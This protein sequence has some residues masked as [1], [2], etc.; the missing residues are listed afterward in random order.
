M[1][2]FIKKYAL[3]TSAGGTMGTAS[4]QYACGTAFVYE[5]DGFTITKNVY[6][7]GE[8][9]FNI[10]GNNLTESLRQESL[11]ME[12]VILEDDKQKEILLN[13]IMSADLT[14][15][16]NVMSANQKGF[17]ILMP[18]INE[19]KSIAFASVV[20]D[21]FNHLFNYPTDTNAVIKVM[22]KY[23]YDFKTKKEAIKL[24]R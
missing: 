9:T 8:V 22:I 1:K 7:T 20:K 11:D 5:C 12:A 14:K 2:N 17:E 16:K 10:D 13:E 24:F 6:N 3:I 23:G 15:V 21:Y 18:T 4:R 19:N